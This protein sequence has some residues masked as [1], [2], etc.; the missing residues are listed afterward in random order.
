MLSPKKSS[1]MVV[2]NESKY[3]HIEIDGTILKQ[4]ECVQYLGTVFHRDGNQEAEI[5]N[6]IEKAS[7]TYYSLSKSIMNMK[8]VTVNTKMKIYRVIYRHILIYGSESW[9][10]TERDVSKIRAAEMK[11]LRRVRGISKLDRIRNETI[12]NHLDIKAVESI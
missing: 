8:E 11:Y 3:A 1:V 9:V 6:R 12:R 4:V 10:L 5:S 7:R 2:S